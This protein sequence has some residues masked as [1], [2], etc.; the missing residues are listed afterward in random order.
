MA[1]PSYNLSVRLTPGTELHDAAIRV[2]NE[3]S[4]LGYKNQD[5]LVNALYAL[6]RAPLPAASTAETAVSQV[7][8]SI[9][10]LEK[11]NQA[12]TAKLEAVIAR[13]QSLPAGATAQDI[14]DVRAIALDPAFVTQFTDDYDF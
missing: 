7:V 14:E 1:K 8:D 4:A 13:L 2:A 12:L 10:R 9:T 6:A 5:I 3:W 11:H